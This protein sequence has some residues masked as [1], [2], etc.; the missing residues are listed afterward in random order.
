[1]QYTAKHPTFFAV[2]YKQGTTVRHCDVDP[3]ASMDPLVIVNPENTAEGLLT[4]P[5]GLS[6][7]PT[8]V[9]PGSY[10]VYWPTDGYNGLP[11]PYYLVIDNA[12]MFEL[13]YKLS[14]N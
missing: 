3:K 9:Q 2:Q 7:K 11:T 13:F 5:S 10:I 4:M 1:M 14:E 8:L 12:F 6:G